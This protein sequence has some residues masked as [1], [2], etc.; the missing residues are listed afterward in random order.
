MFSLDEIKSQ[1]IVLCF[2]EMREKKKQIICDITCLN[3]RSTL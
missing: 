3:R 2:T 1:G